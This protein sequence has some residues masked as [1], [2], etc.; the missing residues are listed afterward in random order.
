MFLA[1]LRQH[2]L[3]VCVLR[4]RVR[5]CASTTLENESKTGQGTLVC[6]L[7]T[8]LQRDFFYSA[9]K[10]PSETDGFFVHT[11]RVMMITVVEKK[12]VSNLLF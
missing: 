12:P 3:C 1:M 8:K 9:G 2:P 7:L 5:V 11:N 6:P 4:M 10:K